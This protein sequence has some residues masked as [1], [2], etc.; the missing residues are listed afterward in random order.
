MLAALFV[1][2]PPGNHPNHHSQWNGCQSILSI[3]VYNISSSYLPFLT[4]V[5][6]VTQIRV[7]HI[8]LVSS[9]C[10]TLKSACFAI[11]FLPSPSH[12]HNSASAFGLP[13]PGHRFFNQ[14]TPTPYPYTVLLH[15]SYS[16]L[17]KPEYD[18]FYSLFEIEWIFLIY[19]V[20]PNL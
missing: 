4:V 17:P 10:I 15:H 16:T 12:G 7:L 19:K 8:T 13:G 20:K 9:I 11:L 3:I 6:L 1:A 2:G 18:H 14:L 5:C